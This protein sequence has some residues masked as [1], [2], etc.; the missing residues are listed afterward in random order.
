MFFLQN[1]ESISFERALKKYSGLKD[2]REGRKLSLKQALKTLKNLG[3]TETEARVYV[4]LSK[5]GPLEEKDLVDLLKLTKHQLCLS[6]ENLVTKGMVR[7]V[8]ERSIKYFAIPFEKVLEE[9][10]KTA[11]EKAEALQASREALLSMWSSVNKNSP[12]G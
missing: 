6:L 1:G 4:Y 11:K 5:K 3:L 8:P 10:L 7:A 12:N 9:F 2:W